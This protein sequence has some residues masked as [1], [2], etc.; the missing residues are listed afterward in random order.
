MSGHNILDYQEADRRWFERH[1]NR[2]YRFRKPY[3]GEPF[4]PPGAA[5]PPVPPGFMVNILVAQVAPGIRTRTRVVHSEMPA[6]AMAND[7]AWIATMFATFY[8]AAFAQ[9][10]E[11]ARIVA[12]REAP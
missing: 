7:D 3:V 12:G 8:P 1:P 10:R 9:T 2:R 5:V 6:P 11:I 4:A